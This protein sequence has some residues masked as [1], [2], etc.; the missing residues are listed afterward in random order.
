MKHSIRAF[1]YRRFADKTFAPSVD[2]AAARF[3]LTHN[4]AA[5]AYE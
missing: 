4:E 5:S 1:V 3:A 2:E